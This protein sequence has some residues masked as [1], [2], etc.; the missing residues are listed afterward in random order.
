M[1]GIA[2]KVIVRNGALLGVPPLAIS[3]GLWGLLPE[4]YS[5]AVFWRDVP[6]WLALGDPSHDGMEARLVALVFHPTR[7]TAPTAK[8]RPHAIHTAFPSWLGVEPG[9]AA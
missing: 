5:P 1:R 7:A 9:T 4:A 8:S 2:S 3:L 6:S